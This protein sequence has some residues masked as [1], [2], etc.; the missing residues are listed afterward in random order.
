MVVLCFLW[1]YGQKHLVGREPGA[2]HQGELMGQQGAGKVQAVGSMHTSGIVWGVKGLASHQSDLGLHPGLT[3]G[4][5][6]SQC[7]S[8]L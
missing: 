4:M 5:S 1:G 6:E 3:H 7:P 2:L 8:P